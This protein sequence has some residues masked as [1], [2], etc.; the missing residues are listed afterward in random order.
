MDDL[1]RPKGDG[2]MRTEYG[3]SD[4]VNFAR[5]NLD[6]Q[7]EHKFYDRT[8]DKLLDSWTFRCGEEC[9]AFDEVLV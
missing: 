1:L 7:V 9:V 4:V 2:R 6:S 5:S 3:I 8:H